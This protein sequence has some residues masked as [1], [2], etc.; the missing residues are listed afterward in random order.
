MKAKQTSHIFSLNGISRL[1][2]NFVGFCIL[3]SL[4]A[5]LCISF[6]RLRVLDRDCLP[7]YVLY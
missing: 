1:S 4:D 3:I 7:A 6:V 5:M 2:L